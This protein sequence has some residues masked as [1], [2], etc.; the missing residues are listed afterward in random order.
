[1]R[2]AAASAKTAPRRSLPLSA[3]LRYRRNF[4]PKTK[5]VR[6]GQLCLGMGAIRPVAEDDF[7][8][9]YEIVNDAAQACRGIIPADRRC[10]PHMPLKI[11]KNRIVRNELQ[12]RVCTG[13]HRFSENS[14]V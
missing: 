2:K 11:C 13:V 10:E 6:L 3:R 8:T 4:P 12:N 9:V 14:V 5:Q 7:E 1:M